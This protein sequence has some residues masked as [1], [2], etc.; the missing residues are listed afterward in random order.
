MKQIDLRK[1]DRHPQTTLYRLIP[2]LSCRSCQPSPPFA[3]I[4]KLSQHE[5]QSENAPAYMPKRRT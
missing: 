3:P 5:W 2:A 4:V 1:L